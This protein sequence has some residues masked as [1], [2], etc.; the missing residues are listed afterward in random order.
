MFIATD[1]RTN[2]NGEL[3][4]MRGDFDVFESDETHVDDMLIFRKGHCRQYPLA[5][6]GLKDFEKAA[7][8][9]SALELLRKRIRLQLELDG[10]SIKAFNILASKNA[11]ISGCDIEIDFYRTK[12]SR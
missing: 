2:D 1:I 5:G 10:Y 7:A 11:L 8:T 3:V 4:F 9:Q 6:V 12:S